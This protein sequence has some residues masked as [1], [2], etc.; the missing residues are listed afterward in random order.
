MEG[1]VQGLGAGGAGPVAVGI[2]DL[3]HD[4]DGG[5]AGEGEAVIEVGG[6]VAAHGVL[7]G[8]V[9][10]D[11]DRTGGA[12]DADGEGLG[13]QDH[14]AVGPALEL[15]VTDLDEL[16]LIGVAVDEDAGGGA[17]GGAEGVGGGAGT[18]LAVGGGVEQG[19]DG[20]CV[21]GDGVQAIGLVQG[22]RGH[23]GGVGRGEGAIVLKANMRADL[24]RVA[25]LLIEAKSADIK[26]AVVLGAGG[27][28]VLHEHA[29]VGHLGLV[30]DEVIGLHP[31]HG[32][33]AVPIV[34]DAQF[35][36]GHRNPVAV[37]ELVHLNGSD[38]DLGVAGG[39]EPVDIV[40][41][42]FQQRVECGHLE[43]GRGVAGDLCDLEIGGGLG[44]QAREAD[45]GLDIR[46]GFIEIRCCV[47]GVGAGHEGEVHPLTRQLAGGWIDRLVAGADGAQ[48]GLTGVDGI[49]TAN[50]GTCGVVGRMLTGDH[51]RDLAVADHQ[52]EI[53]PR[54]NPLQRK[55]HALVQRHPEMVGQVNR[56]IR[57]GRVRVEERLVLH[58]PHLGAGH[59]R[60]GVLKIAGQHEI[61][62]GVGLVVIRD[63]RALAPQDDVAVD[64]VRPQEDIHARGGLQ[65]TG[66]ATQG[67]AQRIGEGCADVFQRIRLNREDVLAGVAAVVPAQ[68]GAGG[69]MTTPQG[70]EPGGED[71]GQHGHGDVVVVGILGSAR[72]GQ[73]VLQSRG[74]VQRDIDTIQGQ[75]GGSRLRLT[76]PFDTRSYVRCHRSGG[77]V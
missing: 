35:G 68:G 11:G 77:H 17:V 33:R 55:T 73:S 1:D 45:V 38:V 32:E 24:L 44:V 64:A 49:T 52:E 12:V 65:A 28:H 54:G 3:L 62:T 20:G 13:A 51:D 18:V 8:G 46:F 71:G 50:A 74:F 4:A 69:G 61:A 37:D 60:A 26:T 48:I 42:C 76:S 15:G 31:L 63:P 59:R 70:T 36:V 16:D 34:E 41:A 58:R 19:D 30:G 29:A 14:I 39:S 40:H 10:G 43:R 25:L 9:L 5:C 6:G 21:D 57:L 22:G 56:I 66:V 23:G 7:E 75:L 27:P 2:G 67:V 53:L 47:I 72:R